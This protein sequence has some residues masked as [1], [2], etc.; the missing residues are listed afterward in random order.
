M[1]TIKQVLRHERVRSVPEQF[2]W[3]DH[4][5]VQHHLI[6]RCTS[7]SAALYLFLVTV[8]DHQ[9]LSYYSASTLATRLHLSE[10]ELVGARSQLIELDLIAWQ[11]PLY[12]V[13]S[14]PARRPPTP[15]GAASPASPTVP[16][17]PASPTQPPDIPAPPPTPRARP[18]RPSTPTPNVRT[19]STPV[20]LAQLLELERR[21]AQL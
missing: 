19:H 13:L 9:G 5:L 6:D 1:K 14:L 10:A 17:P 11:A 21:H 3:V 7:Q 8:A 2:S 15:P 16:P 20:S 18:V 12:Q 4:T